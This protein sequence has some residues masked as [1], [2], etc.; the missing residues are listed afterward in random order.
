MAERQCYSNWNLLITCDSLSGSSPFCVVDNFWQSITDG[1]YLWMIKMRHAKLWN[2]DPDEVAANTI[3]CQ[4]VAKI[5]RSIVF[6]INPWLSW[7]RSR[8]SLHSSVVVNHWWS[9]AQSFYNSWTWFIQ[10]WKPQTSKLN[11]S[12]VD[13]HSA[14]CETFLSLSICAN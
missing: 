13:I 2:V 3:C 8:M 1:W 4:I 12:K 11:F 14:D 6:Y 5:V 7:L 9:Q 10:T